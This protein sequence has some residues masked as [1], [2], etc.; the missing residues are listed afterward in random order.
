MLAA[1]LSVLAAVAAAQAQCQVQKLTAFDA[2][3]LEEFGA[4]VAIQGDVAVIRSSPRTEPG[5]PPIGGLYV[6]VR[7]PGSPNTWQ[8]LPPT[9]TASDGC[10]IGD[11]FG[12]PAI[13]GDFVVIGAAEHDH[14]CPPVEHRGAAYVFMR[15][16]PNDTPGNPTDDTWSECAELTANDA[17]PGDHFGDGSVIRGDTILVGAIGDNGQGASYVFERTGVQGAS[18]VSQVDIRLDA[19]QRTVHLYS[20]FE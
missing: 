7:V 11:G 13:D 16:D 12:Q 14:A 5:A 1:A 8:F 18:Y 2:T 17:A 15:S 9:L 3:A 6:Y 4:H 19:G 20:F 10:P